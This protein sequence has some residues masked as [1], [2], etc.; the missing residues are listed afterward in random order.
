MRCLATAW[1]IL[2]AL[3]AMLIACPRAQ[4]GTATA[5]NLPVTGQHFRG[6]SITV[7]TDWVQGY[8]LRPM[9][10]EVNFLSPARNDIPL[11]IELSLGGWGNNSV[12]T[13]ATDIVLPAGS[14]SVEKVVLVPQT[15]SAQTFSVRTLSHGRE[16]EELSISNMGL[17]SGQ[18]WGGDASVPRILFVGTSVPDVSEFAFLGAP[19]FLTYGNTINF[20]QL[21]DVFSFAHRDPNQLHDE[22]LCYSALDFIMLSLDDARD[23]ASKQPKVW[24]AIDE[25]TRCGGSLCVYG[26]HRDWRGLPEIEQLLKVPASKTEE[27]RPHR[28]WDAAEA[29]VFEDKVIPAIGAA[30]AFVASQSNTGASGQTAPG[31]LPTV[32]SKPPF[33]WK[34]VGFGQV[35][36]LADSQPFPGQEANWRWLFESLGTTS[37]RWTTRN[38]TVPDGE[39]PHFNDFLISDVGLPPIRTYRVLITL[40]VVVIGP[41]N[42]WFL[43]RSGRLHLFL[44]SV[45]LA[46]LITSGGLLSYAL[47]S[48]GLVSRIRARSLTHLDQRSGESASIARLSY[49][50]GLAPSSGLTFPLGT[51][52]TPL[53]LAPSS[54]RERGRMMLWGRQEY[55][56]RGWL[57]SRNPTQYVTARAH[58]SKRGLDIN[59]PGGGKRH[60]VKNRLGARIRDLLVVDDAGLWHR[61]SN[62]DRDGQAKLV[63]LESGAE[64]ESVRRQFSQ[65]VG[66]NEP[67]FP[68]A[69]NAYGARENWLSFGPRNY[70]Y[71]NISII[72][73]ESALEVGLVRLKTDIGSGSLAPRSYVAIV[74]RPEEIATGMDGLTETQSLH[75]IHGTW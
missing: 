29:Q 70:F 33:L 26:A 31:A 74:D 60:S 69:M 9:R 22:W 44:F 40:F 59:S 51:L 55:L 71:G 52:V 18:Y 20:G 5:V 12:A 38:G 49:Y 37:S 72:T 4:A 62:I 61:A 1:A 56:T 14:K 7:D 2:A 54:T 75:V 73:S 45:P 11:R 15:A 30:A 41:L 13:V 39:N 58:T 47:M 8:G 65:A 27:G 43:R 57:G 67:A 10:V 17:G 35:V 24:R 42:Y 3:T 32:P 64:A 25:W 16:I 36:A 46:A 66:V 50:V 53:E 28:G 21:K 68:D 6:L 19:P 63:P 34:A 23:L 48:D